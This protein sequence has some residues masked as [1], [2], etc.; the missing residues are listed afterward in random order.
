METIRL[1][2]ALEFAIGLWCAIVALHSIFETYCIFQNLKIGDKIPT[3]LYLS[4]YQRLASFCGAILSE[5]VNF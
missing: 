4:L 3:V 5:Q 1:V 2:T